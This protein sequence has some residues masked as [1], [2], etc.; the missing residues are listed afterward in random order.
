MCGLG[1][2]HGERC[3]VV[4]VPAELVT[5]N[6]QSKLL[7]SLLDD[8]RFGCSLEKQLLLNAAATS[9]VLVN[10]LETSAAAEGGL[11]FRGFHLI[12]RRNTCELH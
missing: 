10:C 1:D 8:P 6:V 11:Y 2:A 3:W 5:A 12:L 7:R 4:R 9:C